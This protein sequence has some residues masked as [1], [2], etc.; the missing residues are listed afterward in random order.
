MADFASVEELKDY[1]NDKTA[2]ANYALVEAAR[3]AAITELS[4]GCQRQFVVATTATARRFVAES[5]ELVR[6]DDCT[7]V[8]LVTSSGATVASADYQLEP[9]N[10]RSVTGEAMPYDRIRLL[11]GSWDF[12]SSNAREATISITATWGWASIPYPIIEAHKILTKDILSN[13]DVRFGLVAITDA[14]GVG[15]R[16]NP[17]VASAVNAYRRVE[18]FG[19]A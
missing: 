16:T 12:G 2:T 18:A 9:L 14:A 8:T 19:V 10:G 4:N 3:L 17:V 7:T 11:S 13:R 5:S 15:A 1:V 6:M